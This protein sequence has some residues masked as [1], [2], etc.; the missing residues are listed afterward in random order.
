MIE[1]I[2]FAYKY[3]KLQ[4]EYKK[5]NWTSWEKTRLQSYNKDFEKQIYNKMQEKLCV[6]MLEQ[7]LKPEFVRWYKMANQI[8]LS[9]FNKKEETKPI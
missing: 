9:L 1:A 6:A 8:R 7:K 4:K 3:W 2:I 5:I